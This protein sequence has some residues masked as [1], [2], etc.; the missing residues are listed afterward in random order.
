MTAIIKTKHRVR[1]AKNFIENFYGG[2]EGTP[3]EGTP[4]RNHYIFIGKSDE[5]E[6]RPTD[7]EGLAEQTPPAPQNNILEDYQIWDKMVALKQVFIPD[8]IHV[9]PRVDWE[10]PILNG[11]GEIE[12]GIVYTE[13][14]DNDPVLHLHPTDQDVI[15][16]QNAGYKPAGIYTVTPE[17]HVFKCL[18]N[19]N[20]SIST[21]YP[22]K[23][24]QY[25]WIA[26]TADGYKW[27]YMYT[28]DVS[29]ATKFLTDR[30]M[31]V[32][33]NETVSDTSV[34]G[35]IE[36]FSVDNGGS[37]YEFVHVGKTLSGVSEDGHTVT[38]QDTTSDGVTGVESRVEAN[39][40]FIGCYIFVIA[41]PGQG[42]YSKI[43][44]YDYT[45]RQATLEN[46]LESEGVLSSSESTYDLVPAVQISGNGS[47]LFARCHVDTETQTVNRIS[48]IN[49]G[50]GYT[51]AKAEILGGLNETGTQAIVTPQLS[52][53]GGHGS[54]TVGELGGF[55]VM[56]NAKLDP[57]IEDFPQLNDYRQI[58]LIRDVRLPGGEI[59]GGTEQNTF[60]A[61]QL[62]K[63]N[64]DNYQP[65][66]SDFLSD[67]VLSI[68][69]GVNT[70]E[71]KLIE[72]RQEEI[73]DNGTTTV[74]SHVSFW[75]DSETGYSDISTLDFNSLTITGT[76]SGAVATPLTNSSATSF[77][78]REVLKNSGEILWIEYRR[79]VT[80]S[81]DQTEEIKLILEF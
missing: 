49:E 70:I 8:V 64:P 67:E 27:K 42:A 15:D 24:A 62:I 81:P 2:E 63:L 55:F 20:G 48:I 39:L 47:Y 69:D 37:G 65:G 44:G 32:F 25:P 74:S 9:I 72:F 71:A 14:R 3:E 1:L 77:V 10:P 75:Q 46:P 43:T 26:E 31:P 11:E 61:A 17:Y 76:R 66:L 60:S 68:S 5:W 33:Q 12:S 41:G 7:P 50:I 29:N 45:T 30:W 53:S 52:P 6:D 80:R 4:D 34:N 18:S 23:P 22:E 51:Y 73:E 36:S 40:A 57:K 78:D 59:A 16:S 13:Y 38:L 35:S 54:D 28:I 19:N 79:R 58:G 56:L 21:A